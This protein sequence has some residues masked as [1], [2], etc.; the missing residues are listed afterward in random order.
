MSSILQGSNTY[1]IPEQPALRTPTFT[2]TQPLS[3]CNP[4]ICFAA[5]SER[6]ITRS[7]AADAYTMF[8]FVMG[9]F[10]AE[11]KRGLPNRKEWTFPKIIKV[12]TRKEI[13]EVPCCLCPI[14]N[15]WGFA[16]LLVLVGPHEDR[17]W[18]S[19]RLVLAEENP[20]NQIFGW[21]LE[22]VHRF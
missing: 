21:F 14:G 19:R 18:V 12:A 3:F 9:P 8:R 7:V 13:K 17:N 1:D 22:M 6:L 5:D 4:D 10:L 20:E 2:W 15:A 11:L 16:A